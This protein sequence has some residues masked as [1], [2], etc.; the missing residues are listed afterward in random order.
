MLHEWDAGV[1][2]F[3]SLYPLDSQPSG[4]SQPLAHVAAWARATCLLDSHSHRLS[5]VPAGLF[6]LPHC[7]LTQALFAQALV[8]CLFF[9]F[10]VVPVL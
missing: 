2:M 7:L 8:P 1:I 3:L 10:K 4:E 5:L 9:S 6:R